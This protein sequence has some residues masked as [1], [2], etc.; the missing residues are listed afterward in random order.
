VWENAPPDAIIYDGVAYGFPSD[1]LGSFNIF[2]GQNL[3]PPAG[4][5]YPDGFIFGQI[6][7]AAPAWVVRDKAGIIANDVSPEQVQNAAMYDNPTEN[8]KKFWEPPASIGTTQAAARNSIARGWGPLI[9][10]GRLHGLQYAMSDDVWFWQ[11]EN[12]P[13]WYPAVSQADAEVKRLNKEARAAAQAECDAQAALD[14]IEQAERERDQAA[15]EYD[16]SMATNEQEVQSAIASAQLQDQQAA[17]DQQ[18]AQAQA[19]LQ[20]QAAQ[21]ELQWA[22]QQAALEQQTQ[23]AALEYAQAHPE[24]V[25]QEASQQPYQGDG[26]DQFVDEG[27]F[28]GDTTDRAAEEE[29]FEEADRPMDIDFVSQPSAEIDANPTDFDF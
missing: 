28:E 22:Q 14:R 11:A 9:G 13:S 1:T 27:A 6:G 23:Q 4:T 26:G 2:H 20:M 17:F 10:S 18:Q 5:K 15:R 25:Q 24:E 29:A 12:A 8:M 19:Q 21:A 7:S 16:L 3:P